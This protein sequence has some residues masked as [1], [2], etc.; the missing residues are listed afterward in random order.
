MVL[1]LFDAFILHLPFIEQPGMNTYQRELKHMTYSLAVTFGL[2]MATGMRKWTH[3]MISSS[4]YILQD[5]K[6]H[7]LF[8]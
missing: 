7:I 2:F 3:G 8:V 4:K 1:Q 6:N 5:P